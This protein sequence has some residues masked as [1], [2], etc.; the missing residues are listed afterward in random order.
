MRIRYTATAVADLHELAR[1]AREHLDEN[2]ERV[3]GATIREAV[4]GRLRRF[5]EMG[6]EGQVPGTRKLVLTRINVVVTYRLEGEELRV[7]S[8][9]RAERDNVWMIEI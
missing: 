8:V 6:Q 9:L 2:A 1:Y 4:E 5:P 7:L 3:L